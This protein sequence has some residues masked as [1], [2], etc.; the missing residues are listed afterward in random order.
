[1]PILVFGSLN[2]DLVAQVPRLPQAGETLLGT[3]FATVPG[4]TGANQAVAAARPGAPTTLL[5]GV[6]TARVRPPPCD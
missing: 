5:G 4:G 3:G 1:M 2:M 6:G